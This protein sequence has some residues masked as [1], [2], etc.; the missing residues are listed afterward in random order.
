MLSSCFLIVLYFWF[1]SFMQDFSASARTQQYYV[2]LTLTV[3]YY[4]VISMS[5]NIFMYLL[6]VILKSNLTRVNKFI[7]YSIK[8]LN[9]TIRTTGQHY[10]TNKLCVHLPPVRI[11]LTTP[12][13]QDQCSAAELKRLVICGSKILHI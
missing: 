2:N 7:Y 6:L 8:K 4:S 3:Y 1:L 5:V 10:Q 12:G 11:E 13:L 9:R